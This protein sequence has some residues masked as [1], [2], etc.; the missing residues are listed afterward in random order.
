MKKHMANC[1]AKSN[2]FGSRL[3]QQLVPG[4][5][6]KWF[7][8][9]LDD[10]HRD[11]RKT[12]EVQAQRMAETLYHRALEQRPG[13]EQ[14]CA[15]NMFYIESG[16]YPGEDDPLLKPDVHALGYVDIPNQNDQMYFTKSDIQ[17]LVADQC[18]TFE[19][20]YALPLRRELN[21]LS[22]LNENFIA[23]DS[24]GA[25]RDYG[26]MLFLLVQFAVRLADHPIAGLDMCSV[27]PDDLVE[28][29]RDAA[30]DQS[31]GK[32]FRFVRAA[33]KQKM[34]HRSRAALLAV[35]MQMVSMKQEGALLQ[36]CN[37][38]KMCAQV[39]FISELY[40]PHVLVKLCCKTR[41]H[42]AGRA[43]GGTRDAGGA[44]RGGQGMDFPR[45]HQHVLVRLH[46][47]RAC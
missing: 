27:L 9:Y 44:L 2:A 26:L 41:C 28:L 15:R 17:K 31:A 36:P 10:L 33:F 39:P 13:H 7:G 25:Q 18:A 40:H 35:F 6:S 23:L 24:A 14:R 38:T 30:A 16:W 45:Q 43:R 5:T 12:T 46:G 1:H 37:I 32:V 22:G 47:S 19:Q 21:K 8:V 11:P 20:E 3:V 4:G 29:A 42:L 34:E